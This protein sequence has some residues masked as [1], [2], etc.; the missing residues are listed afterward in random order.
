MLT[1]P[2]AI[3]SGRR[4]ER[5]VPRSPLLRY[6]IVL[7]CF[8]LALPISLL[9]A[10]WGQG[11]AQLFL[12]VVMMSAWFGGLG[13]GLLATALAAVVLDL[14][15]PR[16]YSLDT[17]V[18]DALRLG[19]FIFVAFLIN[20][21]NAARGRLERALRKQDQRKDEFLAVLAH[22]LRNPLGVLSNSLEI[23]RG[24]RN[25]PAAVEQA[26]QIM[27]RQ[28]RHV[29]RLVNDLFDIAGINQGKVYLHLEPVELNRV[30]DHA[31]EV[32]RP[33][34]EARGHRLEISLPER[35]WLEA[36][37]ARLEQVFVNLLTNAIKYTEKAGHVCLLG[38]QSNGE[39]VVRVR[40]NGIGIPP[41][42]LP[43]IFDLYVQAENGS[44]SGLGIGLSLVR[45][46]VQMHGGSIAAF[47]EGPGRGSEFVVR[48]LLSERQG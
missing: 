8:S 13:P 20:S 41:E 38:E 21:L 28:V 26:R 12:A 40:D 44:R 10:S 6:G 24:C 39:V 46:L 19:V 43:R 42:V 31:V 36:D 25:N 48:L 2:F 17:G 1:E 32:V 5:I 18:A 29:G 27:D 33:L 11:P 4:K 35:V 7:L 3:S 22:E 15:L 37:P 45:S 16:I 23:L 30:V 14:Y 34:L 47:S 9:L